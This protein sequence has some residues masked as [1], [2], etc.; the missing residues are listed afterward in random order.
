MIAAAKIFTQNAPMER[1][2]KRIKILLVDTDKEVMNATAEY[3]SK[4]GN[5][6][7]TSSN[8]AKAIEIA[9]KE[10]PQLVL[11]ELALPDLDGI[12]LIQELTKINRMKNT[13]YVFLTSRNH[14]YEQIA[15]FDSGADDYII[16]P[17]VMD[18]LSIRIANLLAIREKLKLK[19]SVSAVAATAESKPESVDDRFM[20]KVLQVID[21]NI[22]NFDF[23]V[24]MLHE[25]LGMSRMHLSRKLKVLT[26]LS[27]RVLI[28]NIRLEKAARLLILNVGNIT[29]VAYSVG[30]SNASGFTKAF[31]DYFGV[32][33]KKYS[34][35]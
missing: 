1:G 7:F 10:L 5:I 35:Q 14:D 4:E 8:S 19:Y 25:R 9:K 22:S 12:E 33:P 18:E 26:D 32:S 6:V 28:T 2:D 31:R 20:L 15:A 17:F 27:P 11:L 34:R 29:E 21:E 23:D 24:G 16:K 13:M 30:F 3:L